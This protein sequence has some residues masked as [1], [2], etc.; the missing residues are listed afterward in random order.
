VSD[1]NAEL[2]QQVTALF[3]NNPPRP[4]SSSPVFIAIRQLSARQQTGTMGAVLKIT[5]KF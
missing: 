2:T 4:E 1:I 3:I 5:S